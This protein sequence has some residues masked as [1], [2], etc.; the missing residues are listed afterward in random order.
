[1]AKEKGKEFSRSENLQVYESCQEYPHSW[2][3]KSPTSQKSIPK[4]EDRD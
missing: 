1:M 4:N 3:V 2:K